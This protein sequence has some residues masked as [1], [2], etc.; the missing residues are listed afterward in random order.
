[1]VAEQGFE[2]RP[3]APK[4][5][6]WIEKPRLPWS[7]RTG[8]SAGATPLTSPV[9]ASFWA[10]KGLYQAQGCG[11]QTMSEG[12]VTAYG[13]TMCEVPISRSAGPC[14]RDQLAGDAL[15][16]RVFGLQQTVASVVEHS[17]EDGLVMKPS[18]NFSRRRQWRS[19]LGKRSLDVER[20]RVVGQQSKEIWQ[21]HGR[22]CRRLKGFTEGRET[23]HPDRILDPLHADTARTDGR[24]TPH[25]CRLLMPGP[26]H[27]NFPLQLPDQLFGGGG[28]VRRWRQRQGTR[29]SFIAGMRRR[30]V[31]GKIDQHWTG[32]F[33]GEC[34][35]GAEHPA[36]KLGIIRLTQ[37]AAKFEW[38]P[39]GTG[40]P[41]PFG[42]VPDEANA[43][44]RDTGTFDVMGKPANGA[45]TERSDR[46]KKRDINP[47]LFE[48]S[49]DLRAGLFHR[50][51]IARA[52][53]RVVPLGKGANLG[54]CLHR[55]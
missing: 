1:M 44:G 19:R 55:P 37:R 47:V 21:R 49:S 40:R 33:G 11:L 18:A 4:T 12:V 8:K 36:L 41:D 20:F 5:L 30:S 22:A 14:S 39:Q 53:E 27:R 26:K 25:S 16:P 7:I 2:P 54:V 50:R 43:G 13:G 15:L 23:E 34:Q 38:H 31:F 6:F 35:S 17:A 3:K 29:P 42:V 46:H 45:R 52:H 9:V 24:S 48:E 32:N 10:T 51:G 28:E